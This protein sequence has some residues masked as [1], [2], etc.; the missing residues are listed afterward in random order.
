V[1][2]SQTPEQEIW[3][4]LRRW[5]TLGRKGVIIMIRDAQRARLRE[6]V[7]ML[8]ELEPGFCFHDD[9][10]VIADVTPGS[11]VL[12]AL[13]RE[14][15]DWLNL[16]RPLF[17]QRSLRMVLWA[18]GELA[19]EMKFHAPDL[20]DWV[21]HFV[22]CPFGVPE[23]AVEALAQ[24]IGRWPG[25]AW[26]GSGLELARARVPGLEHCIELEPS[27]HYPR[28]IEALNSPPNCI[29]WK[30]V[31]KY[32]Q[33][34]RIRLASA[35]TGFTGTNILD[36][37]TT[38]TPEW[39]Q[40]NAVQ[41]CLLD[42]ARMM[43]GADRYRA[44]ALADLN[45]A[46]IAPRRVD[47]SSDYANINRV[48]F[49][50]YYKTEQMLRSGMG[51]R[52][53]AISEIDW[54]GQRDIAAYWSTRWGVPIDLTRRFAQPFRA[55]I[56]DAIEAGERAPAKLPEILENKLSD[57]EHHFDSESPASQ[58]ASR[59]LGLTAAAF[60][61]PSLAHQCLAAPAEAAKGGNPLLTG[62]DLEHSV[63]QTMLGRYEAALA[64]FKGAATS[65]SDYSSFEHFH[66]FTRAALGQ[67]QLEDADTNPLSSQIEAR[68]R[69]LLR[70]R[71]K[72]LAEP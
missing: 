55:F 58:Y 18:E 4:E 2:Q 64:Q 24:S 30:N 39:C 36:N 34:W 66:Q 16:N 22:T 17:A 21:S 44:V 53:W 25:V 40:V 7:L 42:A 60:A 48:E 11:L 33:L 12:L 65:D 67:V 61:H 68:G 5:L 23:F 37:P 51:D 3:A 28:I 43:P 50:V 59:L 38:A 13:R 20:H 27:Q 29:V 26:T 56:A 19:V 15:L 62:A 14:D 45:P 6:L 31:T 63:V 57:V 52:S 9:A 32:T 46:I 72:Q 70:R 41:L 1:T 49:S 8:D 47:V 10:R 54:R 71:L 69:A 35:E